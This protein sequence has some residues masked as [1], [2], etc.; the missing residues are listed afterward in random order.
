[1]PI[2]LYK[3][4]RQI[5]NFIKQHIQTHGASP[6]LQAI[7]EAI[8]VKS[9]ATVHEHLQALEEKE[10][11]KR[12]KGTVRGIEVLDDAPSV[13]DIGINIPILGFIAAGQPLEPFTD[14]S[15]SISVN[16]SMITGKKTAYS[17]QVKGDSMIEEGIL[18]IAIS[19][20][21][22]RL[23]YVS[24]TLDGVRGYIAGAD[25]SSPRRVWESP[26]RSW[27]VMFGNENT[28]FLVSKSSSLV[29]GTALA[30]NTDNGTLRKI[31]SNRPGLEIAPAPDASKI[32]YSETVG[33]RSLVIHLINEEGVS[34]N[35]LLPP[36]TFAS[37]CTWGAS[38]ASMIVCGVP[39]RVSSFPLPETWYQGTAT[40]EDEVW[41]L[42][43]E[44]R[45]SK[46]IADLY[47]TGGGVD[48]I[49]PT[50]AGADNGSFFFFINKKDSTLWALRITE[51]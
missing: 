18:D 17:L 39:A 43:E 10:V 30:L 27:E 7:A 51:E 22:D 12:Y 25:G 9:L 23:F 19:P 2:T 34:P 44:L 35:R 3:R 32:L 31:V 36:P 47:E 41:I 16:P 5:L 20:G 42:N 29:G 48:I 15:A 21:G 26:L 24:E 38:S 14:P 13:D 46:K 8:G 45:V 1:M 37:K 28:V 49:D 4:Q 6:T 33:G 40:F 50:L 11:I